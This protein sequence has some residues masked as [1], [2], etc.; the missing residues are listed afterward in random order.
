MAASAEDRETRS[1]LR[2]SVDGA[3]DDGSDVLPLVDGAAAS[4]MSK[5]GHWW[6]R[7]LHMFGGNF[8]GAIML[9]YF[10]QGSRVGFTNLAVDYYYQDASA[11][12]GREHRRPAKRWQRQLHE[13]WAIEGNSGSNPGS[14][15]Q[16]VQ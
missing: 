6:A 5:L 14:L 15:I 16:I 1:L 10:L 9:V 13:N 3:D 8:L 2:S 11:G 7:L 12:L 4:T